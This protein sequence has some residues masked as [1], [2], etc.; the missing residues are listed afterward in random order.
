[1]AGKRAITADTD[2]R[3]CR[4]F[5]QSDGWWLKLQADYDTRPGKSK[6]ANGLKKIVPLRVGRKSA[7]LQAQTTWTP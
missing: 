6:L 4:P 1:V 2:L 7:E 5:G 3:L